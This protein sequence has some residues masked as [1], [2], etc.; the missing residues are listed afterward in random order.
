VL[1]CCVDA[2]VTRRH[3]WEVVKDR[4]RLF[5]DGRMAAEVLRVLTASD[6]ASR[7]HY[8][9]TL[10]A[11]EEAFAGSCTGRSTIYTASIAAG[12]MVEQLARWLRGLP[13]DPDLTLNLLSAEL[14]LGA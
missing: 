11:P 14:T 2:I 4:V 12:L 3:I 6:G 7:R 5:I 13:T 8:P 1:F 9:T 10:F